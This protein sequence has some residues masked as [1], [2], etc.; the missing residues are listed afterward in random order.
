V[1]E[2]I[3]IGLLAG[4][5]AGLLGV[6]GGALF[7]PALT[8]GLGLGQLDAEATSLL[9][10]IPVAL[11]GAIR[12]RR[13]RNVDVRTGALVGMLGVLGAVTGAALANA[14]PQRALEVSFALFIL[15]VAARLVRRALS[16]PQPDHG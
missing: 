11:V 4:I 15:F 2:A 8:L 13:H 14:V 12:Q 6:G 16:A 10:I 3:A 7:V 1:I 9:A 5:V